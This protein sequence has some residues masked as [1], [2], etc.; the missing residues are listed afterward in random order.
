MAAAQLLDAIVTTVAEYWARIA[1]TLA[2]FVCTYA[3]ATRESPAPCAPATIF[4][5]STST[6]PSK[7]YTACRKIP[8][9]QLI[10]DFLRGR[11]ELRDAVSGL[12]LEGIADVVS[13]R[14][15]LGLAWRVL[16]VLLAAPHSTRQDRRRVEEHVLRNDSLLEQVLGPDRLPLVGYMRDGMPQQLEDSLDIQIERVGREYLDLGPDDR[17]LDVNAQWGDLAVYLAHRFQVPACAIVGTASQLAHAANVAGESQAQRFLRYVT[18]DYRAIAQSLPPGMPPFTKVVA[19]DVLDA[20]GPR[21]IPLFLQSVSEAM[22]SGGR[23]LLQTTTTPASLGRSPRR[24]CRSRDATAQ[25][26]HEDEGE[27]GGG[28]AENEQAERWWYHWFRQRY[29]QPGADTSMQIGIEDVMVELQR[30]GFEVLQLES[31]TTDAAMTAA[32]WCNRLCAAKRQIET[33]LG[34]GT[35]RSWELYMA[36]TQSM[37]ARARLQKHFVLAVK[38]A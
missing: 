8:A 17:L 37:Y 32:V 1:V 24:Q 19:L 9:Q 36:W 34:E 3:W 38:R 6:Y 33:E 29:I 21:N 11:I 22:E 26:L 5:P 16:K 13:F 27:G 18:G 35:Y 20:I 15:D 31:L 7:A 28:K 12:G 30:A 4:V 25:G 2:V 14:Y 10:D 23:L